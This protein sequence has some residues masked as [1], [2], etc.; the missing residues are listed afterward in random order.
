VYLASSVVTASG[1]AITVH[2]KLAAPMNSR[3]LN[4]LKA[5]K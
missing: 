1:F 4:P 3:H 2:A 5:L